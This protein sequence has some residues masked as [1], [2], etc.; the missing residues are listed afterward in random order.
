MR[1]GV[2]LDGVLANFNINYVRLIMNL[3]PEY[4]D[5]FPVND[6]NWPSTWFYE[7]AAGLTKE[8]EADVWRIIK[9]PTSEFWQSL[10]EYS[11]T[12]ETINVLNARRLAGDDIYYITNRPGA[13]AKLQTERWL[14]SRG[15]VCPTVLISSM[16]GATAAGIELDLFIDD[17][18]EN[19]ADVI[20]ARP[21][22]TVFLLDAPYNRDAVVEGA[23][24]VATVGEALMVPQM[25]K[26]A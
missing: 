11:Q 19:C 1:I 17:R 24:R 23:I 2:D 12:R 21:T 10:A 7:R 5:A 15:A 6:P 4:S 13:K 22:A 14:M 20:A 25:R 18:P 3:F 16:K 8:Q 9:A 26:V